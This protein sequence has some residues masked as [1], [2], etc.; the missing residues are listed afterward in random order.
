LFLSCSCMKSTQL[1]APS[2]HA[3]APA[4][5]S[6]LKFISI[7][8]TDC[9]PIGIKLL[10][11]VSNYGPFH[12]S[13]ITCTTRPHIHLPHSAHHSCLA[14]SNLTNRPMYLHLLPILFPSWNSQ[15]LE[16]EADMPLWNEREKKPSNTAS[17]L[18]RTE[19]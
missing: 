15:T 12:S 19:L 13:H 18:W 5:L 7:R 16:H 9:W 3:L 4:F 2:T 1:I 10:R 17:H 6:E 8:C 14:F 11:C